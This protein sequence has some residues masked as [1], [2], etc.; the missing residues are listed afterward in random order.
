[1]VA[2]FLYESASETLGGL[3]CESEICAQANQCRFALLGW[4]GAHQV[5][6]KMGGIA[7]SVADGSEVVVQKLAFS[8]SAT[9]NS[10]KV[11]YGA[12]VPWA[13]FSV[14]VIFLP[15]LLSNQINPPLLVSGRFSSDF[16]TRCLLKGA[17]I[18]LCVLLFTQPGKK[19]FFRHPCLFQFFFFL[20]WRF[21]LFCV[22]LPFC[23]PTFVY[24]RLSSWGRGLSR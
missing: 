23:L 21:F 20:V 4:C 3:P 19:V 17:K 2:L 12:P 14:A 1:M 15:L 13:F 10:I 18:V 6:Q 5:S 24:S 22:S 11:S 8:S 7:E 9:A 16:D